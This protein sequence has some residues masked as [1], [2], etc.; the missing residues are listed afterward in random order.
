MAKSTLFEVKDASGIS[1]VIK[2]VDE[3]K[4][5]HARRILSGDETMRIHVQGIIVKEPASYN[6]GR[7]FHID[8]ATIDFFEMAMEVCD[9][10]VELIEADLGNV[11]GDFLP[12]NHWCPWSSQ[13]IREI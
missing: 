11:G 1:F 6:P 2:L 10:T 13:L 4:I 7:M 12:G 3:N 8:P 5:T 9:A